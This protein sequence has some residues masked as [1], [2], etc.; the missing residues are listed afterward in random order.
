MSFIVR[1]AGS[2]RLVLAM[3]GGDL[4]SRLDACGD[5]LATR[6]VLGRLGR[7][8]GIRIEHRLVRAW[9]PRWDRDRWTGGGAYSAAK[10]GRHTARHLGRQPLGRLLYF[11]GEAYDDKWAT[12]LPGAYRTGVMA[13]TQVLSDTFGGSGEDLRAA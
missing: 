4:A 11:A 3:T 2:T 10:P 1:P 8:L 13:A 7:L 9:F 5:R 6:Y 12:Y